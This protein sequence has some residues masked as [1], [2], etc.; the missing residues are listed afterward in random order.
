[1]ENIE[2]FR[3]GST[4]GPWLGLCC[5]LILQLSETSKHV[6]IF[7]H[8]VDMFTLCGNM[9]WTPMQPPVHAPTPV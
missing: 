9:K 4:P 7:C 1:M 8:L 6:F 5:T 3:S 2:M